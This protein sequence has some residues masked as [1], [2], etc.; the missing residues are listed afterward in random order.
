MAYAAAWPFAYLQMFGS[1]GYLEMQGQGTI[2]LVK[3]LYRGR[4]QP[5]T[6]RDPAG[7]W[8][9]LVAA[10]DWRTVD[11]VSHVIIVGNAEHRLCAATGARL[12]DRVTACL[13]S[14]GF[15]PEY[16]PTQKQGAG[17]SCLCWPEKRN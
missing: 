16:V 9:S 14:Q 7:C 12:W 2:L 5:R 13:P 3:I 6:W 15:G 17:V 4:G 8:S 10:L 11:R 1:L